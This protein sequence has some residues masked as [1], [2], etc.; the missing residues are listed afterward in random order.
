MVLVQARVIDCV[1]VTYGILSFFVTLL[2]VCIRYIGL[3]CPAVDVCVGKVTL[4][5]GYVKGAGGLWCIFY[6][7]LFYLWKIII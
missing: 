3:L 5:V 7:T 1:V 4:K 2:K 6:L